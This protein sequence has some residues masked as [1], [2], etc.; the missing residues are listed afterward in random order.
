MS[1]CG[2]GFKRRKERGGSLLIW[3]RGVGHGK[4][5]ESKNEKGR[6]GTLLGFMVLL[7]GKQALLFI[8]KLR[9][10][11]LQGRRE[12]EPQRFSRRNNTH[13]YLFSYSGSS[14]WVLGG[15]LR[16]GNS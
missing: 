14:D 8:N 1:K 5:M 12:E 16:T 4:K 3:G 7:G 15:S 9:F 11:S 10:G 13:F 6:R 2:C